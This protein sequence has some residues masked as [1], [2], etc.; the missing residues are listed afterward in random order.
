M[1][2]RSSFS[3]EAYASKLKEDLQFLFLGTLYHIAAPLIEPDK[4]KETG[5]AEI[6]YVYLFTNSSNYSS[7][8]LYNIGT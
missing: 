4:S 6:F 1:C 7:I 3:F 8:S 2:C 5:I